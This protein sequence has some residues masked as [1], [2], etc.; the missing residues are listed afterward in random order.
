MPARPFVVLVVEDS[1]EDF[2]TVREATSGAGVPCELLR[3]VSGEDCLEKLRGART[4]SC[5]PTLVL[6]DLRI[7]G[8]DG[9]EVLTEI[10][11]EPAWGTL[12]VVV[13]STSANPR[14]VEFCR[15]ARASEY[16]VKPIRHLEHVELVKKILLRWL[17]VEERSKDDAP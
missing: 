10:R 3:S 8:V 5:S 16:H 13:L 7:P 11:G 4:S 9:R 14:D 12:P 15:R 1:D 17:V 6:L 2:D